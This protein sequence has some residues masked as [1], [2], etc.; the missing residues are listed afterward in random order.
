MS[1]AS[2]KSPFV[3]RKPHMPCAGYISFPQPN[4]T[5][6]MASSTNSKGMESKIGYKRVLVGAEP[7]AVNGLIEHFGLPGLPLGLERSPG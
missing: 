1:I 4:W 2:F 5:I 3:F 6:G 7:S